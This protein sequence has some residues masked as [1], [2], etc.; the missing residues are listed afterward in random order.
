[1]TEFIY[2]TDSHVGLTGT[3][4]H[5]QPLYIERLPEIIEALRG[6]LDKHENAKFA[7]HGGDM[8]D[9]ASAEIKF[10]TDYDYEKTFVQGRPRDRH[11]NP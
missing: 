2:F 6:W 1:M 4:Y 5:Q 3:G 9:E 10:K 11:L 8:I 7:L